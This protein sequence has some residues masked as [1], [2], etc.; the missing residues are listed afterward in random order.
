MNIC[1]DIYVGI[2]KFLKF[3]VVVVC[4]FRGDVRMYVCMHACKFDHKNNFVLYINYF[5]FHFIS[6]MMI[7]YAHPGVNL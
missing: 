3:V 1:I 2:H 4:G 6:V 7:E 5:V